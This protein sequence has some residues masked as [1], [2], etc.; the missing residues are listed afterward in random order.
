M[1]SVKII[2]WSLVVLRS[3]D[4][5]YVHKDKSTTSFT[6]ISWKCCL[7]DTKCFICFGLK[8]VIHYCQRFSKVCNEQIR[9]RWKGFINQRFCRTIC[10]LACTCMSFQN[11][12]HDVKWIQTQQT[13]YFGIIIQNS[14]PVRTL[15][16]M[17]WQLWMT[18]WWIH[19]NT[20]S[21][22][23]LGP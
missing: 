5:W 9:Y 16:N 6:F 12:R 14:W 7:Y 21:L 19:I 22:L 11:H 3:H 4:C 20:L 8:G 23:Y 18:P 13:N 1:V 10:L 2:S 17:Y 15:W